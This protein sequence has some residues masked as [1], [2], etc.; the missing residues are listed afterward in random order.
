MGK[1]Y[2][3][4]AIKRGYAVVLIDAFYKRGITPQNKG[5]FPNAVYIAVNLK[6]H[7]TKR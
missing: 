4:E 1:V 5:K 6:K 7:F 3:K 2:Q